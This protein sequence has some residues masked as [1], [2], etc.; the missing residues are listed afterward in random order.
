MRIPDRLVL[1]RHAESVQ[2]VVGH[3]GYTELD[4]SL[5][6]A[7]LLTE[8]PNCYFPLSEHG[9]QQAKRA[10]DFVVNDPDLSDVAQNGLVYYSPFERA[11][12]TKQAVVGGIGT[13]H[14]AL[15]E[16]SYGPF[17]DSLWDRTNPELARLWADHRD[18][19]WGDFDGKGEGFLEVAER[20]RDFLSD[21][22]GSSAVMAITHGDYMRVM[23]HI[24]EGLPTP[25]AMLA[26]SSDRR[27]DLP[28]WN[29]TIIEYEVVLNALYRR[30]L[31]PNTG[32]KP[33][34]QGAGVWA[35]LQS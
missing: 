23:Q 15:R 33:M 25:D 4:K 26:Q 30:C 13:V 21:A 1:M 14:D 24:I 11:V 10:G 35:K 31:Y 9:Q 19:Y 20:G 12:R 28:M 32:D 29:T 2:N 27:F 8:W 6:D 22:I 3:G 7:A 18:Y 5:Y 17:D 34:P 16:R